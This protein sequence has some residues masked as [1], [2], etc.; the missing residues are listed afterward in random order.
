MN[1]WPFLRTFAY[2]NSSIF[3]KVAS[4][5][6]VSNLESDKK[7]VHELFKTVLVAPER[8]QYKTWMKLIIHIS[9]DGSACPWNLPDGIAQWGGMK[10][11]IFIDITWL[12]C[13]LQTKIPKSRFLEIQLLGMLTWRNFAG[14]SILISKIAWKFRIEF[15]RLATCF[16]F[17]KHS[18]FNHKFNFKICLSNN[19]IE[20]KFHDLITPGG[21]G[22]VAGKKRNFEICT[23]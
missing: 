23:L 12:I 18:V 11:K 14:L 5:H 4:A 20:S 6:Y 21:R 17:C 22:M 7:S 8:G 19:I 15:P 3:K 1:S 9:V 13:K 10:S 2:L 16:I